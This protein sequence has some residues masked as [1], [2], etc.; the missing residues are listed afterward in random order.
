MVIAVS[1]FLYA[2]KT[3]L[4][5]ADEAQTG[6]TRLVANKFY[7]DE[8]YDFVF[9]RPIGRLS[10]ALHY[11]ADIW[12]I[13]GLVNGVAESVQKLGGIFRRLQNGNIEYYLLGMVAGV[14]G[15]LLAMFL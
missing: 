7:V 8:I 2:K 1:W 15:L 11:Y 12:A 4:P 9:V 6:L 5:V 10:K 14:I 13:D 3:N